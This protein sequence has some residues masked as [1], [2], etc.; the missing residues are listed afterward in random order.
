MLFRFKLGHRFIQRS[1]RSVSWLLLRGTG[2][3]SYERFSSEKNTI[4]MPKESIKD[5]VDGNECDL[6][7]NNLT[8]VPVKELVRV[9]SIIA[10]PE[11][12]LYVLSCV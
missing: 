1:E 3:E 7:L 12:R 4:N 11:D 2:A 5:K 10:L 9:R 8:V 6:S